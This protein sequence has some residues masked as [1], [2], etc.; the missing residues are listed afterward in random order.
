MTVGNATAPTV[1]GQL[2]LA[3]FVNKGGL[4]AIGDNLFVETVSSG[5]ALVGSPE[6]KASAPCSRTT[7]RWRTWSLSP[8]SPR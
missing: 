5:A 1:L 8:N 7:W 4:E 2:Q 6:T 3:R